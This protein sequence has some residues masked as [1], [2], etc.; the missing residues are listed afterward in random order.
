[1]FSNIP[2]LKTERLILRKM[3]VKDTDDMYE[4]A[5]RLDVTKFLTWNPHPNRNY[6]REYLEYISS[7]YSAGEFYDWAITLSDD[8]K[9]IGTCGFTRFDFNSN[10][11]EVGYVV[12]PEY[13]NN[14]YASEALCAVINFGFKRLALRRIEARH[15]EGNFASRR[16]MEKVGMMYEGTLRS[17]LLVK[18]DYKNICI[19]SLINNDFRS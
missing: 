13:H 7:R 2:E 1:M 14:G 10:L 4:Y 12:N 9:M 15:I 6:T 18:G 5:K 3:L 8:G 17:S 11:A 16:V 19:C